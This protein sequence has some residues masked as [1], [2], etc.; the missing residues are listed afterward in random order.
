MKHKS[1]IILSVVLAALAL[2]AVITAQ[3][4]SLNQRPGLQSSA[5]SQAALDTT[6]TY[7]GQLKSDGQ[8]VSGN[9]QMAFRL[10]DD[11]AAGS[12]VGTVLSPPQFPSATACSRQAWT[13]A[14]TLSAATRAG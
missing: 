4:R 11:V 12:Q 14:A 5:A 10:Y 7:Q 8:A 1:P 6:F 9:C 3:A 13:L 2:L